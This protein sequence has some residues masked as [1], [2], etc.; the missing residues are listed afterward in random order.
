VNDRCQA[1]EEH[2]QGDTAARLDVSPG[3]VDIWPVAL[4]VPDAELACLAQLLSPAERARSDRLVTD[5][6]R[7]RW[8]ACRGRLRQILGR[9]LNTD[10]ATIG[11]KYQPRGKPYLQPTAHGAQLHF[12][13]SHSGDRAVVACAARPVGVDLELQPPAG[14]LVEL[15]RQI[16]SPRELLERQRSASSDEDSNH[17]LLT[18]WVCKEALAKALGVGIGGGLHAVELPSRIPQ[19]AWFRPT[20]IDPAILLQID[21]DGTCGRTGW[22]DASFWQ[23]RLLGNVIPNRAAAAV[24]VPVGIDEMRLVSIWDGAARA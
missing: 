3:R 1:P 8:T 10:P 2:P 24:A 5:Q 19:D 14:L 20:R 17:A 13:V 16:L 4:D 6:L 7:R 23:I 22:C 18:A 21:D 9:Y 12:N 15:E 11:L